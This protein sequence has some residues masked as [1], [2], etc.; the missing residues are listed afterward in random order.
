MPRPQPVL[1]WGPRATRDDRS[2]APPLES[3]VNSG[4]AVGL[5]LAKQPGMRTALVVAMTG[6]LLLCG[7]TE[8]PF[9]DPAASGADNRSPTTGD[10]G[11]TIVRPPPA[12]DNGEPGST[13]EPASDAGPANADD[14]APAPDL[15]AS[16]APTQP[17]Q[18]PPTTTPPAPTPDTGPVGQMNDFE[19]QLFELI[20]AE[21]QR[22]GLSAFIYD[23]VINK[24]ARGYA[25]LMCSTGHYGHQ[26]P[27]GSSPNARMRDGGVQMV[28]GNEL[29]GSGQSTPAEM[30]QD[31]MDSDIHHANI[32]TQT[33]THV[34]PGYAPCNDRWGHYWVF[35]LAARSW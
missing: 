21:R 35:N 15:G 13:A 31:W 33:Y 3:P 27:D 26:G 18:G 12:G 22:V 30:F 6:A 23:P 14:A 32:V 1:V 34:S 19:Q 24:V 5:V 29:I 9:R 11:T 2:R 8:E 17:D 16:P 7:C 25:E 4:Q 28:F 10:E 20:N